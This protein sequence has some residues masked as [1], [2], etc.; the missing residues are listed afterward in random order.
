MK[1]SSRHTASRSKNS[2]KRK[3][4]EVPLTVKRFIAFLIVLAIVF[5]SVARTR[6]GKEDTVEPIRLI[7]VG[8]I[9]LDRGV[10]NSIVRNNSGDYGKLFEHTGYLREADISFANLEGTIGTGTTERASK[11]FFR[12]DPSGLLAMRDAG[13][14]I[15]SLAN[16]HIGDFSQK[17]FTET[18][19]YLQE[20]N[21]A[22]SGAGAN[23]T[24][25]TTPRIFD[26]RGIRIGYLAATDIGSTWMNATDTRPGILLASDK[27]LLEIIKQAK[28]SVDILIFSIHWGNEYSPVIKR[29]QTLAYSMIDAG[30]DIVVGHHPH[31]IQKKEVY[32]GKLIYY[33]LGNFIFDQYFS[34]HT[35]RGMVAEVSIDPKSLSLQSTEYISELNK[36][37]IPQPLKPFDESLL[38]SKTFTP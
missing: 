2:S 34:P 7:F 12:M 1:R 6:E 14:D 32:K 31:V 8:D 5:F 17:G 9:M 18:L 25:A 20:N 24:E 3:K 22:A 37:F 15:V 29:Q 35:M 10:R 27:N 26:I 21:I 16:N 30:V 11:F 33:S 4:K 13:I 36:Q 19:R 38:I 23:Y 28:Q